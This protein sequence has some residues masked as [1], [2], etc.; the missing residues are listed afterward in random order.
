[1]SWEKTGE[2]NIPSAYA[3]SKDPKV[4]SLPTFVEI[5]IKVT[6]DTLPEG[7]EV[8]I[9]LAKLKLTNVGQLR[10]VLTE[11]MSDDYYLDDFSSSVP[12]DRPRRLSLS[13]D[14]AEPEDRDGPLY[15]MTYS[16]EDGEKVTKNAKAREA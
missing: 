14:A 5:A 2:I 16:G 4:A 6:G 9:K 10:L 3:I 13:M 8:L 7:E 11:L 12:L 1:M 15:T